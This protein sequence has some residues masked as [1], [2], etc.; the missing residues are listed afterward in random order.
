M[1]LERAAPASFGE[2]VCDIEKELKRYQD[3]IVPTP[4]MR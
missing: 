1:R 2:R 4:K 3:A